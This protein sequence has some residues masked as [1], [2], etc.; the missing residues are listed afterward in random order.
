VTPAPPKKRARAPKRPRPVYRVVVHQ[1]TQPDPKAE[2]A[3]LA[4]L[5]RVSGLLAGPPR[6]PSV[7]VQL[8]AFKVEVGHCQACQFMPGAA[9]LSRAMHVHHVVPRAKGGGHERENL[10]VLC[11]RCHALAHVAFRR[12]GPTWG[13]VLRRLAWMRGRSGDEA[14]T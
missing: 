12:R 8:H 5:R 11:A 6:P 1:P 4:W 3:A 9:E 13:R 2:A 10:L 7:R 14:E